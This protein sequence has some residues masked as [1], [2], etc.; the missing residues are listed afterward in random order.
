MTR[1]RLHIVLMIYQSMKCDTAVYKH[2]TNITVGVPNFPYR[3]VTCGN[4]ECNADDFGAI[5][6]NVEFYRIMCGKLFSYTV[7]RGRDSSARISMGARFFAPVQTD[8]GAQAACCTMGTVSLPGVEISW[9]VTLTPH[10]F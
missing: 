1:S 8:P 9:S 2:N 6:N 7:V 3:L 5:Y 10:P 4:R